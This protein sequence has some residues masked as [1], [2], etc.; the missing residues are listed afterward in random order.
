MII[1]SDSVCLK[2]AA[3]LA[4]AAL[5]ELAT[6]AASDRAELCSKLGEYFLDHCD[7]KSAA[8]A[9]ESALQLDPSRTATRVHLAR[10]YNEL[11]RPGDAL[12]MLV[13]G[14]D[15]KPEEAPQPEHDRQRGLSIAGLCRAINA[16][17][18]FREARALYT[19]PVQACMKLCSLLRNGGST[20]EPS[21]LCEEPNA[22]GVEYDHLLQDWGWA[23]ELADVT[24]DPERLLFD[25][26]RIV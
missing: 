17:A 15:G 12:A 16:E 14:A 6:Q 21:P 13:I 10:T 8:A 18:E 3:P 23:L 5:L 4:G 2:L 1:L 19:R 22:D 11:A 20:E 26:R 9:F 24:A 7:F 25:R